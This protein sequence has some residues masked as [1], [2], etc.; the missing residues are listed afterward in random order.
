LNHALLAFAAVLIFSPGLGAQTG[1]AL[2]RR[3][4]RARG[5]TFPAAKDAIYRIACGINAPP[6]KPDGIVDR[7]RRPADF[8]FL[9]DHNGVPIAITGSDD[10]LSCDGPKAG[11]WRSN[12]GECL[13]VPRRAIHNGELELG[14]PHGAARAAQ[15]RGGSRRS[16]VVSSDRERHEWDRHGA[17]KK[18]DASGFSKSP[19]ACATCRGSP[20]VENIAAPGRTPTADPGLRGLVH[21]PNGPEAHVSIV[22]GGGILNLM[23]PSDSAASRES[24]DRTAEARQ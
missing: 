6:D 4:E 9:V 24:L 2:S 7:L 15:R 1:D 18:G 20:L 11:G 10:L 5:V 12:G 22:A 17:A 19:K 13:P 21:Y 16:R 23:P 3:K 14:C 8:L